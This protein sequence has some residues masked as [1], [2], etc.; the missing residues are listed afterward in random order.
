[1]QQAQAQLALDLSRG[2]QHAYA[3]RLRVL[4][5]RRWLAAMAHPEGCEPPGARHDRAGIAV[6]VVLTLVLAILITVALHL[7]GAP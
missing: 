2:G 5:L 1:M 3:L 6:G 4:V 7:L